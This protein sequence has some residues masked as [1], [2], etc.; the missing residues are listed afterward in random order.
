MQSAQPLLP[1]HCLYAIVTVAKIVTKSKK[2]SCC[3]WDQYFETLCWGPSAQQTVSQE[4]AL[5]IPLTK[6]PSS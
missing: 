2:G 1:E 6:R 4:L 3:E 5:L